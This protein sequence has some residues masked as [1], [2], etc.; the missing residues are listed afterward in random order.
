[1]KVISV[2]F[3]WALGR[4]TSEIDKGDAVDSVLGLSEGHV[5]GT[6]PIITVQTQIMNKGLIHWCELNIDV[7]KSQR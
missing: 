4:L 7:Q 3:V 2:K 6:T 1:M 5:E